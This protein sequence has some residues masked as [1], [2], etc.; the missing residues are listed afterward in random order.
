MAASL[1]ALV[2]AHPGVPAILGPLAGPLAE[3]TGM[4]LLTVLMTQVIGFSAMLLPYVSAPVMIAIQL[5]NVGLGP[6]I[7]LSLLLGGLTLLGLS[8]LAYLWWRY[9]G[10][11]G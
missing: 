5:T 10:Y 6:A 9:L 3:T 11:L 7:R 4:P 8:P 1:I 2:T